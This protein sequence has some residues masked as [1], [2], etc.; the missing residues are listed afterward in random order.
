MN[1]PTAYRD[2]IEMN[3]FI[4]CLISEIVIVIAV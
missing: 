1:D 4:F 3:I 2:A